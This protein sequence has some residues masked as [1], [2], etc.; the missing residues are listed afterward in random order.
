MSA[1]MVALAIERGRAEI[2]LRES[3]SEAKFQA[4]L[5]SSVTEVVT[6][7][8]DKNDLE[9]AAQ[10]LLTTAL[11]LTD[12]DCGILADVRSAGIDG[13]SDAKA[14]VAAHGERSLYRRMLDE[15]GVAAD[16]FDPFLGEVVLSSDP[17]ISNDP[18][19]DNRFA[20]QGLPGAGE[21][22]N[23]V[24]SAIRVDSRV[25]AILFVGNTTRVYSEQDANAM[26]LLGR[27]ASV[28]FDAYS[29]QR[30]EAVLEDD[31]RQAAKMEAIG[32][33]AGGI[34]HDFNNMLAAVQG[35]AELALELLPESSAVSS[36]LRSIVMASRRS[37]ELCNQMLAY[38]GRGLRRMQCMDANV[39]IREL[40]A[41][42]QVTLS[43]K[44]ALSY[45]LA[46]EPLYLE[47]DAAQMNQ[48]VMNLTTNG[49][50]AIGDQEGSLRVTTSAQWLDRRQLDELPGGG[51]L[52]PGE[53]VRMEMADTGCGINPEMESRIYD[54]FYTT[55]ASGRGLGLAAVRGI[56]R[57]HG[58]SIFFKSEIGQGTTFTVLLP[59]VDGADLVSEGEHEVRVQDLSRQKRILVVDDEVSVRDIHALILER[60]GYEVV[61][62]S[63]GQEAVDVWEEQ[64][65]SL[66]CV[67]LDLSMP[68]LDGVEALQAMRAKGGEVRAVLTSG[69][70]EQEMLDR[71]L[72][73]GFAG[74]LQK[75]A[76]MH[77]LLAMIDRVVA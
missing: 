18:G 58:G 71:F 69:F 42:Q 63:D 67:L 16:L 68:R 20:V 10:R 49:A 62:A 31:L 11:D 73:A 4:R 17:V 32:V 50:E 74:V 44:A 5:L 3:E 48:V 60:A 46:P 56:V 47:A 40:G 2:A 54:P 75:P 35:N 76:P 38:A 14:I 37:S 23:F 70:H 25:V 29:R 33:L 43:K 30:R 59:R 19:A 61:V 66:D 51:E 26:S 9:T 53:F 8:V 22:K 52:D 45:D 12:S 27:A 7:F 55:K 65:D 39:M 1:Q 34:A 77:T 13:V 15:G 72:A 57:G 21:P 64:G 28:L 41:L 36:N 6:S 24:G